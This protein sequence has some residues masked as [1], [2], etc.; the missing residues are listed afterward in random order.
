MSTETEATGAEV[1]PTDHLR[2]GVL[3]TLAGELGAD[4]LDAHLVAGDDLWV[5]V[6]TTAWRRAAEVCRSRLG[7]HYFCFLSAIDWQPSPWGRGEDDPTAPPPERPTEVVQGVAGGD[8]R[9]QVFA[10]VYSVTSK[11]G[12]TLKAD[13]DDAHPAIET[14]TGVYAGANWHERETW[15]MFGVEFTGHPALRNLYLPS[16]F[17]GHPLRKDFPL[18]ARMVKPWPGIVDVEP[19]PGGDEEETAEGEG[20]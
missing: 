20:A 8:T 11:V 12:L 1:T 16:D 3:D 17:E 5:R 2:Q 19:M 18:L 15:E 9:F 13:V 14:W 4:L 7:M 6:A 10:R